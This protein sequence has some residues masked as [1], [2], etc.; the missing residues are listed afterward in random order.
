MRLCQPFTGLSNRPPK[1]KWRNSGPITVRHQAFGRLG[2]K[3][4]ASGCTLLSQFADDGVETE[5]ADSAVSQQVETTDLFC[6]LCRVPGFRP[7]NVL[8]SSD[9][10]P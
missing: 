5:K 1:K 7:L 4:F 9:D 2:L 10:H 3:L 6:N 8:D